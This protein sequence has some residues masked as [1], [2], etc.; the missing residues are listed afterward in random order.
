MSILAAAQ[1]PDVPSLHDEQVRKDLARVVLA[2]FARWHLSTEQQLALLG[3]S[4]ESRRLL[5]QY[6]AGEKPLPGGRDSLDRAGY[7]MGIH[8]GLHL[9]FPEDEDLR[10]RWVHLRNALLDGDSPLQVMLRD[11]LVGLAR[12]A[13]F[14]AFQRG[15]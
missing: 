12:V 5:A 1:V 3:L 8:K 10:Y 14:V 2:L 7:L 11:G 15:Q 4:P 6:R 9:L 13:R